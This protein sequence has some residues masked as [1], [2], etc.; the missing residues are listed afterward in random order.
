LQNIFLWKIVL[1]SLRERAFTDKQTIGST[2][3]AKIHMIQHFD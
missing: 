2:A 3:K 1:K